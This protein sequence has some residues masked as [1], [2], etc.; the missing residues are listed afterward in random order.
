MLTF[1]ED[2]V[3]GDFLNSRFDEGMDHKIDTTG[4]P[5]YR[6]HN[7]IGPLKKLV[8]VPKLVD[9]GSSM[10][11]EREN[12]RGIYPI[13]PAPYRAPEIILGCGWRMSAD[14][15]NLGVLVCFYA[16]TLPSEKPHCRI[17]NTTP[18]LGYRPGQRLVPS[19]S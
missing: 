15:W 1:E 9:F 12:Y 10:K 8:N 7:N 18:A 2:D 5:V 4:R 17:A 11:L 3:L 6:C 16:S 14:I 13:Q 19:I